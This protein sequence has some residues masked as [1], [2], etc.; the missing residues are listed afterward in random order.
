MRPGED[1]FDHFHRR[2]VGD[3]QPVDDG[4]LDTEPPQHLGNLRPAAVHHNRVDAD[5]LEEDDV[6]G[7]GISGCRVAHCVAAIF[8][9]EGPAGVAAHIGKG[10][11]QNG[12]FDHGIGVRDHRRQERFHG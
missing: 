3:P 11:R 4:A 9:D 12:G 10:L 1:H 8:D 5:L 6:A 7:E 2:C